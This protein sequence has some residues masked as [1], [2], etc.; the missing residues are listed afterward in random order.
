[1]SIYLGG[2]AKVGYKLFILAMLF[3]ASD[4]VADELGQ[5]Y[6][7]ELQSTQT[8]VFYASCKTKD[9]QAILAFPIGEK[10]GMFIERVDGNVVNSANVSWDNGKAR[11]SEALGGVASIVRVNSLVSQLLNLPFKLLTSIQ[12]KKIL[13]SIPQRKCI[14]QSLR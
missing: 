4:S 12:I 2:K 5:S 3:M 8:G 10:Q 6:L 7:D 11:V 13:D 14:E 9:G 1:M